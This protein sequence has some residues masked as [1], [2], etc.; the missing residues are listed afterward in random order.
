MLDAEPSQP[1]R[2]PPAA[3]EPAA[4]DLIRV[5]L[6]HPKRALVDAL[7]VLLSPLPDIEVVAAHTSLDWIR[8]AVAAGEVNVLLVNIDAHGVDPSVVER[9]RRTSSGLGVVVVTDAEETTLLSDAVRAGV[10]GWI[11]RNAS[12]EHLVRVIRGVHRGETW[13][14]PAYTTKLLDA[15]LAAEE[16]RQQAW[17]I[18]S[19]LSTREREVLQCLTR[20][21]TRQQIADRYVLSP[22]TVRTHINNVLRKLQVHSTLAAVSIARQAGLGDQSNGH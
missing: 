20:G 3:G 13:F 8:S 2:T 7:E 14:P 15:L 11:G 9:L 12:V 10:R 1:H 6:L 16:S 4:T 21:Q 18:L 19:S 17:G 5:A 22:H